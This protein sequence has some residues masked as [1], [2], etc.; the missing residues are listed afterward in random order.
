MAE[1]GVPGYDVTFWQALFAPAGTPAP[2]V[3]RISDDVN[4][5]LKLPEVRD[6]F[7]A[8]GAEVFPGSPAQLAALLKN[9]IALMG[10]LV[11]RAKVQPD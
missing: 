3:A 6:A 5:S 2:I 1:A 8:Q 9:D 11:R 7:A 4:R 10:K